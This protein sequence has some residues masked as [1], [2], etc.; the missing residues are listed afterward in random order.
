MSRLIALSLFFAAT[1]AGAQQP[2]APARWYRGNTHAHTLNSDGDAHPDVVVRWFRDHGY[3][4]TFITD[5]EYVTDVAPLNALF[6]AAGRFA[7]FSAQEV[8]RKCAR[9][10][11]ADHAARR[12]VHH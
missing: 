10:S 7:V 8:T 1:T 9:D 4:F 12:A 3:N 2:A 6:G 5:H 11:N